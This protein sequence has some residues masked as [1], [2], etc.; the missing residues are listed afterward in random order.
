MKTVYTI[1]YQPKS[2]SNT[3]YSASSF[4]TKRKAVKEINKVKNYPFNN[5]T[6]IFRLVKVSK[7]LITY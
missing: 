3:W 2:D 5:K 6:Y 7:K 1:E 4:S